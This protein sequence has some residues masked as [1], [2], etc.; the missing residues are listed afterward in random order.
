M[1]SYTKVVLALLRGIFY[2]LSPNIL[3]ISTPYFMSISS[4]MYNYDQSDAIDS[5]APTTKYFRYF[6]K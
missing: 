1:C 5:A 4:C 2:I 3:S 6:K